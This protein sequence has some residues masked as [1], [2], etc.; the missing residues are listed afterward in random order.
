MVGWALG[1]S[2]SAP[3]HEVVG[4]RLGRLGPSAI[5]YHGRVLVL[6]LRGCEKAREEL[7]VF[8]RSQ[9]GRMEILETG[10]VPAIGERGREWG[11]G[12]L[13][14]LRALF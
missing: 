12:I 14:A 6:V 9:P 2:A 13:R 4:T 5:S 7:E 11:L 1:S 10:E 8:A 3:G